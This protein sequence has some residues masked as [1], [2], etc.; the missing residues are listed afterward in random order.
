MRREMWDRVE[1]RSPHLEESQ[2]RYAASVAARRG[3]SGVYG[4]LTIGVGGVLGTVPE[5]NFLGLFLT[6]VGACVL[7]YGRTG[8]PARARPG[9]I[10]GSSLLL[11]WTLVSIAVVLTLAANLAAS[12]FT[13]ASGVSDPNPGAI[14]AAFERAFDDGAY[15][16]IA[17]AFLG[18]GAAT[19]LGYRWGDALVRA[20][21]V[22]AFATGIV[23]S[24]LDAMYLLPLIHATAVQ[25]TTGPYI[26][27]GPI[28]AFNTTLDWISLTHMVAAALF[29]VAFVRI[30]LGHTQKPEPVAAAK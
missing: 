28:T 22:A 18:G 9:A 1:P 11:L 16:A 14:S 7:L 23:V 13:Y 8:V 5:I 2:S 30:A 4:L 6:F 19:L 3:Q 21:L 25:A 15:F 17:G 20:L 10:A 12:G 24:V 29:L 27:Q 26:N